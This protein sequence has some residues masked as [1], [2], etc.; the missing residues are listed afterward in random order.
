MNDKFKKLLEMLD[1]LDKTSIYQGDLKSVTVNKTDNS[2]FFDI[3]LQEPLLIEDFRIFA[4][5][6]KL[7]P[8]K[9]QSIK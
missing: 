9:V 5:R 3:E 6:I 8:R 1:L 2:W 4:E 7:L